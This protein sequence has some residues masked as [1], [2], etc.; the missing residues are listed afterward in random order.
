MRKM[1]E[2]INLLIIDIEDDNYFLGMCVNISDLEN[3]CCINH[4]EA[5]LLEHYLEF[6]KPLEC[7]SFKAYWWKVSDKSK[8]YEFLNN[9]L[10]QLEDGKE[11]EGGCN[12]ENDNGIPT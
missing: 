9:L 6:N 5:D 2:L 1:A 4:K 11:E 8:R 3:N 10:A 7:R 12:V